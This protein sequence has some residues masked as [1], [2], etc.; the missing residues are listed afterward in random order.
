MTGAIHLHGHLLDVVITHGI[1]SVIQSTC[2][3]VSPCLYNGRGNHFSIEG[4]FETTDGA[5][6]DLVEIYN[7]SFKALIENMHV[8]RGRTQS[9]N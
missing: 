9:G 8:Y 7:S 5:T 1:N 3:I 6:D 4:L 2:L